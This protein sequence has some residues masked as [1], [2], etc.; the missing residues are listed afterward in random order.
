VA[1]GS[2]RSERTPAAANGLVSPFFSYR[3][4]CDSVS[5]T[6]CFLYAAGQLRVLAGRRHVRKSPN[7]LVAVMLHIATPVRRNQFDL[8][9]GHRA[10]PLHSRITDRARSV[11]ARLDRSVERGST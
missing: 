2:A 3:F 10:T 6:S 5:E 4:E 9:R 11:P 8:D 7:L 1:V